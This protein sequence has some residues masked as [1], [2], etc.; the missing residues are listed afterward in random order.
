MSVVLMNTTLY[1]IQA[2]GLVHLKKPHVD[3]VFFIFFL[4]WNTKML[5]FKAA[6]FRTTQPLKKK[7]KNL[8]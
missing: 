6:L 2:I 8:P 1:Y 7:K 4:P 3:L 5:E